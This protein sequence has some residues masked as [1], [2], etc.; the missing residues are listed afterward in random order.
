MEVQSQ[1]HRLYEQTN[2]FQIHQHKNDAL[3]TCNE[4]TGNY[5]TSKSFSIVTELDLVC[6]KDICPGSASAV[7]LG[8][9]CPGRF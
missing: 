2:D 7:F 8:F 3:Q 6:E 9:T 5:V 1:Q 4:L